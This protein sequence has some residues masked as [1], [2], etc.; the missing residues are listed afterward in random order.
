MCSF[1]YFLVTAWDYDP[2]TSVWQ[3]VD[4][5]LNKYIS[6]QTN[7][8]VYNPK[9]L[10]LFSYTYNNPV[11]LMDPDGESPASVVI[12][13]LAKLGVKKGFRKQANILINRRLGKYM[14]RNLR[15]KFDA[16]L[17]KVID[18]LD[19][20]WWEIG[21]ELIPVVGDIYGA[22]K[23]AK[24]LKAAYNKFQD[25]E[26]KYVKKIADSLSGAEKKR[27]I[28][29]M[30][31][32]GVRDSKID[33]EYMGKPY[34]KRMRGHHDYEA[35]NYPGK[36]TDPRNIRPMNGGEHLDVGHGG[37]FRNPSQTKNWGVVDGY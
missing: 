1:V 4:P 11:N 6:G 17:T 7:G 8:G 13:Q 14:S 25:L 19:D 28:K 24:R 21:I 2:R 5:I 20:S 15:E 22:S 29:N 9:N 3:S 16:D 23:S 27:F 35:Q 10:S 37:N 33:H 26:N 18:T 36:T 32:N 31:R 12:K 30:R 34:E